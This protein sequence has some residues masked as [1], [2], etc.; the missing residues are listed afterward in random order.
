MWFSSSDC[1]RGTRVGYNVLQI[2]RV[3]VNTHWAHTQRS[4]TCLV[5][6]NAL[7]NSSLWRL[8]SPCGDSNSIA[9][10]DPICVQPQSQ[11]GALAIQELIFMRLLC[12][13]NKMRKFKTMLGKDIKKSQLKKSPNQTNQHTYKR[14]KKAPLK[15][16]LYSF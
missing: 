13:S 11:L 4:G 14:L 9:L 8:M 6:E 5:N 7:P 10:H 1:T 2:Q 15:I 16:Q 3:L 12:E